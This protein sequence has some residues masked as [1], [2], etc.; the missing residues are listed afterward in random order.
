MIT[1]ATTFVHE[2]SRSRV[3]FGSGS[4]SSLPDELSRLGIER[5]LVIST[6]GQSELA[7]RIA[8]VIG[9]SVESVYPHARM[10]VPADIADAAV[11]Y[12]R[13]RAIDGCVSVG[14]GSS[15]GLAKM[16]GLSTGL[17]IVA[18]PTT[19]SGSE[20]T[21]VWGLTSEEGKRTGRDE[22]VRPRAVVYD[23]QLT[24]QLPIELTVT[25]AVNALAHAIEASYAPDYTPMVGLISQAS[26]A[27]LFSGIA[28]IARDASDLD[29]RAKL[30]YGA[31]LAGT[32][33][34]ATSMSL[35]HKLCHVLGGSFDLPHAWTHTVLLPYV[36]S[37]N[38]TAGSPAHGHLA[39]AFGET[40][41]ASALLA[42]IDRHGYRRSLADLGLP[43]EGIGLVVDTVMAAPYANPRAV[44]ADD[45]HRILEAA[46]DG[47]DL[48]S[49]GEPVL[50]SGQRSP[51]E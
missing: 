6:P 35:H 39:T 50:R 8:V 30:T 46:Y 16:I 41:P 20:M 10:H 32:C 7:N 22:K 31:W 18:V 28:E 38:L 51:S 48:A 27:A 2:P 9:A 11:D 36:M 45:V 33:L 14:G 3:V 42:L 1:A 49:P 37:F 19:Y 29:A 34:E 40:D 4:I 24:V 21:S 43:R 12:A 17:P 13:E 23:L 5:P 15:V 44:Q 25:S 26:A 47:A